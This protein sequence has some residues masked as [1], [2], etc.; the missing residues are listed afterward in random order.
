MTVDLHQ[1]DL[2]ALTYD[3]AVTEAEEILNRL[4]NEKLPIDQVIEMSKRVSALLKHCQ[5]KIEEAGVEIDKVLA[6]L[7]PTSPEV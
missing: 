3:Q 2:S 7:R 4:E 5:S 6:S 1:E